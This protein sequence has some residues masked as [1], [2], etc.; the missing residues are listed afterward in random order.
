[1]M[2][3]LYGSRKLTDWDDDDPQTLQDTSSK[4][5][6]VVIMKHMF[7]LEELQVSRAISTNCDMLTMSRRILPQCWRSKRTFVKN[8]PSL[9]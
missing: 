1:M 9:E 8:V 2:S 7:T 3:N 6:K 4:W 5:D